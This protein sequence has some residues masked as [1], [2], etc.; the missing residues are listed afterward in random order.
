MAFESPCVSPSPEATLYRQP[1]EAVGELTVP[2]DTAFGTRRVVIQLPASSDWIM[3]GGLNAT[4]GSCNTETQL[5]TASTSLPSERP[6][7]EP[8]VPGN[9][10]P[11]DSLRGHAVMCKF[12]CESA[13]FPENWPC[14]ISGI[15]VQCNY[16]GQS[17]VSQPDS[18]LIFL[19]E[20]AP[21][22]VFEMANPDS[23]FHTDR[24][25][26][27]Y[28]FGTEGLLRYAIVVTLYNHDT[29]KR[30]VIDRRQQIQ[31][32][33]LVMDEQPDL[34]RH[35]HDPDDG[36]LLSYAGKIVFA[37]VSVFASRTIR[38]PVGEHQRS[39]VSEVEAA[40]IWPLSVHSVRCDHLERAAGNTGVYTAHPE[41]AILPSPE[42]RNFGSYERD[43][44]TKT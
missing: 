5:L 20:K 3:V 1:A 43:K 8:Y 30:E 29:Y 35:M 28:L 25:V 33:L 31:R 24:K 27:P 37:T 21:W 42:S 6:G 11:S 17:L 36:A 12:L 18:S 23:T 7:S 40:S 9:S 44:A 13:F 19:H 32:T 2:A 38:T 34:R 16:A 22:L 26:Q 39:M 41:H 14:Y 10:S 15:A 4:A